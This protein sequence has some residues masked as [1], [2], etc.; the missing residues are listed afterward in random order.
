MSNELKSETFK[1]SEYI[2]SLNLS[3]E[4]GISIN[5]Y[6]KINKREYEKVIRSP[7]EIESITK[8][9]NNDSLFEMLKR[10]FNKE[11]GHNV[12]FINDYKTLISRFTVSLYGIF[13]LQFDIVFDK[14]E[15]HLWAHSS[16]KNVDMSSLKDDI[17]KLKDENEYLI[18]KNEKFEQEIKNLN[19]LLEK[20][21]KKIDD[22]SHDMLD[23]VLIGTKFSTPIFVN[24]YR[25]V[26]LVERI[27][28]SGNLYIEC[29]KRLKFPVKIDFKAINQNNICIY[30]DGEKMYDEK[31]GVVNK[32]FVIDYI[33][34]NSSI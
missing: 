15:D 5:L 27:G 34:R 11:Q 19:T 32:E 23:H 29:I 1:F 24:K 28:F 7:L 3:E 21:M 33:K 10:S 30:V 14:K 26:D 13:K 31:E 8:N 22:F 4:N 16:N 25:P 2:V 17:E 18:L 6:D 12:Y 20:C 9:I